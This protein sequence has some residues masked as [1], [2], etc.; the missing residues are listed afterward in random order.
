MI[1]SV[2]QG[3]ILQFGNITLFSGPASATDRVNTSV[4][5]SLDAGVSILSTQL[6]HTGP[7]LGYS[8][9]VL[10]CPDD[11]E[12][13]PKNGNSYSLGKGSFKRNSSAC[14]ETAVLY[15]NGE[16]SILF[17]RLAINM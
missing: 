15:E 14:T 4:M 17:Q 6:L 8:D 10:F 16:P 11:D 2:C 7:V 3:S 9:L 12:T 13:F 1:C 5:L